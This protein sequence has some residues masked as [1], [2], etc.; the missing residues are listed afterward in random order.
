[1]AARATRAL[2]ALTRRDCLSAANAVSVASFAARPQTEQHSGVGLQGRP[3]QYEPLP[4]SARR[5]AHML[6]KTHAD[7]RF[8][9]KQPR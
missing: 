3:P 7:H 8:A 2:R 5:A 6:R 1:M 4:G 9:P